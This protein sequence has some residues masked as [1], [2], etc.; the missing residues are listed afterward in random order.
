MEFVKKYGYIILGVVCVL[1]LGG[2]YMLGRGRPAGVVDTG[3]PLVNPTEVI[4]QTPNDAPPDISETP[5][6][7][8]EATPIPEPALIA[9]H[10]VG[11]VRYP[12][13]YDVPPGS[14]IRDVLALAGG[15]TEDADLEQIN[16]SVTV[17]DAMQIRIPAIGD[18]PQELIIIGQP[19]V[20]TGDEPPANQP[21]QTPTDG[22]ININLAN[23]AELQT[24]PNIG[25]VRARRIIDF[26]EAN[27]GFNSIEDLLEVTGIGDGIFAG[28]RNYITVD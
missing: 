26:R 27:N 16:L 21:N 4:A 20:A 19:G 14:R 24:L 23:F 22:R 7:Q 25:E 5:T 1:A 2:L 10:I 12:D 3:Q 13:V 11:E 6:P 28:L 15:A 9:V 8:T 18:E 17:Q